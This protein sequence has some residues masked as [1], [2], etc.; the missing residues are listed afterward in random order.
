MGR[1]TGRDNQ[2]QES[3]TQRGM[4]GMGGVGSDEY[5]STGRRGI[6]DEFSSGRRGDEMGREGMMGRDEG[7]GRETGIGREADLGREAGMGRESDMGRTGEGLGSDFG[8]GR[9]GENRGVDDEFLSSRDPMMGKQRDTSDTY[10]Q[11][12]ARDET[13]RTTGAMGGEPGTAG[14][15]SSNQDT[16]GGGRPRHTASGLAGGVPGEDIGDDPMMSGRNAS[17]KKQSS[18]LGGVSSMDSGKRDDNSY[19][20]A[21]AGGGQPREKRDSVTGKF[22]EKAGG[23]FGSSKM[24]EKGHQRRE[25]RQRPE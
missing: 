1:T 12:S 6:D 7:Y 9:T 16:M 14:L 23:L 22:M 20:G 3:T 19:G 8:T 21:Y 17:S 2:A 24:E 5:G 10:G 13:Q 18:G 11:R 25:A 4:G 15:S